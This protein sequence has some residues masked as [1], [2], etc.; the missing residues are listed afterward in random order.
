MWYIDKIKKISPLM[1][2]NIISHPL[3]NRNIVIQGENFKIENVF[4]EWD[5]GWYLS[6][7]LI[8]SENKYRDYY[9]K[10][11]FMNINSDNSELICRINL[12]RNT[13]EN[14]EELGQ[15]WYL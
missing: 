5:F 7:E 6:L 11:P 2:Y 14:K 3:K 9:I 4:R 8:S 13:I 15:S 1:Q 12:I 10:I